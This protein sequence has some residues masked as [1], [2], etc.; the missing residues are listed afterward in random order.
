[1]YRTFLEE[2][3]IGQASLTGDHSAEKRNQSIQ[4]FNQHDDCKV[5]LISI[6]AGGVGLNLTAANYIL[7]L[8]PWWNPFVEKQ[9][10]ARAH[11]IGQKQ[12][13]NVL[14]FI[15][16]ESIE[17]K[18]QRLQINKLKLADHFV[19]VGGIPKLEESEVLEL[20]N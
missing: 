6:K 13:V 14:R 9:A 10:I 17:E 1:M 20:I 15:S 19:D 4:T 7:I 3:G 16:K 5:F 12:K 2:N 11:R 8:D 18:I